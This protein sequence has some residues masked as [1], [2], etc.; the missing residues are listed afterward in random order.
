MC[1]FMILFSFLKLILPHLDYYVFVQ[2]YIPVL[3][4]Y[5]IIS[6]YLIMDKFK[7]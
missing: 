3:F 4:T 2:L 6:L 5:S 7:K 1:T